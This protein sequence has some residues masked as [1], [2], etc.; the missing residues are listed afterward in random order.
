MNSHYKQFIRAFKD[1]ACVQMNLNNRGWWRDI[2][3]EGGWY[4]IKSNASLRALQG[5]DE[6]PNNEA[7]RIYNIP[8]RLEHNEFLI[9]QGLAILPRRRGQLHVV[10]SG[11]ARNLRARAREHTHGNDQTGCLQLSRYAALRRFNWHFCYVPCRVIFPRC[12]DDKA[13]RVFG[14]QLW[15]CLNGWPVLCK[16]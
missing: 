4:W 13:L 12:R 9:G 14:E 2:P 15:R 7:V 3:A 8:Q 1:A 10:Y 6:P 5:L 16:K 11:E